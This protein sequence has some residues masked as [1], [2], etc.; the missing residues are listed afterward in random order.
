MPEIGPAGNM[1]TTTYV[2]VS[3]MVLLGVFTVSRG[4]L[5]MTHLLVVY[6][7]YSLVL[8]RSLDCPEEVILIIMG[9]IYTALMH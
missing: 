3:V 8:S 4:L 7:A 6:R 5:W 9:K 2:F 1:S